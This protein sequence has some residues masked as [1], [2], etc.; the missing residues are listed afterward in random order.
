ML[1]RC[2]EEMITLIGNYI[3]LHF[4]CSFTVEFAIFPIFTVSSKEKLHAV[5]WSKIRYQRFL[6]DFTELAN[7]IDD[8]V[9]GLLHWEV[10]KIFQIS[11]IRLHWARGFSFLW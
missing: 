10:E 2:F 11:T 6:G 7:A 4:S 8:R 5:L 9:V 3:H 1:L